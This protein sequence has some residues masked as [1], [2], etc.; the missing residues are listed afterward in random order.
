MDMV[1]GLLG[2]TDRK[3]VQCLE[4]QWHPVVRPIHHS[5]SPGPCQTAPPYAGPGLPAF[6]PRW[7][8]V[9]YRRG[10][11]WGVPVTVSLRA[12]ASSPSC[13]TETRMSRF[14]IYIVMLLLCYIRTRL[15]HPAGLLEEAFQVYD[16]QLPLLSLLLLV[17]PVSG[18]LS[19]V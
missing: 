11:F 13:V 1:H 7:S 3:A 5:V 12:P 15:N 2:R 10:H 14:P 17:S 19:H 6:K 18:L 4:R 16:C 9:A 8:L